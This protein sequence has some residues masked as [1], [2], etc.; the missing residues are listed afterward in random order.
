M[1]FFGSLLE[2]FFPTGSGA[3][4]RPKSTDR[5][6]VKCKHFRP[7]EM[8]LETYSKCHS[9]RLGFDAV[10]GAPDWQYAWIN[11]QDTPVTCGKRGHWF[12]PID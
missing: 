8:K 11:R 5:A 6:C 10:T 2:L 9:P 4:D 1:S 7:D 3:P 12:E